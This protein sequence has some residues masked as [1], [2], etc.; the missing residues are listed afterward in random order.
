MLTFAQ[1]MVRKR[2][3]DITILDGMSVAMRDN[4][5]QFLLRRITL[6]NFF[7]H[8]NQMIGG[9]PVST[10]AGLLPVMAEPDQLA[11]GINVESTITGVTNEDQPFQIVLF[12]PALIAFGSLRRFNQPHLLVIANGRNLDARSF[13]KITDG[14][15][16]L[17]L[18][19]IALE[20]LRFFAG[21]CNVKGPQR[22]ATVQRR[23]SRIG[24][25]QH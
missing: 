16:V 6:G 24:H 8:G 10:F 1:L 12:I 2:T 25:Y 15:H 9:N 19:P 7:T 5:L 4:P 18:K 22:R 23:C 21:H 17:L 20:D 3:D 14:Q 13:G 11:D